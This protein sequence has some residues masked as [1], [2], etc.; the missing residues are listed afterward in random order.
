MTD[1]RVIVFA[2]MLVA[3]AA[4]LR[5]ETGVADVDAARNPFL[6]VAAPGKAESD[7]EPVDEVIDEEAAPKATATLSGTSGRL[8][9]LDREVLAEGD[10]IRGWTVDS[11][12]TQTIR[13]SRGGEVREI[14]VDPA[15]A[16]TEG[17]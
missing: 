12:T 7:S 16:N 17:E 2:A 4:A 5:A 9:I 6:P 11:I 14:V 10:R 8:V 13:L 1:L 15:D 3:F